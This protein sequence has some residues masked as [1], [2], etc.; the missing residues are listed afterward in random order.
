MSF[1][2]AVQSHFPGAAPLR[3]FIRRAA[4]SLIQD[5][6]FAPANTLAC[7]GVCRDELCRSLTEEVE[8][9][10]GGSFDFSS[11]AGILSLGKTGFAAAQSHAPLV[12]GRRRYVFFLFTHIGISVKGELGV[13][14]RPGLEEPTPACGA[15][16]ALQEELGS[17]RMSTSLNW[18][19]PEMSLLKLRLKRMQ[20]LSE[21]PDLLALTMATHRATVEDLQVLMSNS[22]NRSTEDHAVVAGVEIHGPDGSHLIWT[23]ES[24]V[25]VE[26]RRSEIWF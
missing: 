18:E 3:P 5:H 14:Q 16:V 10:W 11:L 19:D 24:Y 8:A 12:I 23:G 4:V 17:G 6:G 2:E 21:K 20:V 7:V 22:M 25:V 13:A 1:K 15:L 9:M 26:G